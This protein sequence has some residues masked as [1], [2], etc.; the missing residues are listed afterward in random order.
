MK[1]SSTIN[2]KDLVNIA[3]YIDEAQDEMELIEDDTEAVE[4]MVR[5]LRDGEYMT[6]SE[7]QE[8]MDS[9]PILDVY[10]TISSQIFDY[11]LP[12]ELYKLVPRKVY[13]YAKKALKNKLDE[14]VKD[15]PKR[16]GF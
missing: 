7:Y 14:I 4:K 13:L 3:E 8:F 6:Q 15:P 9:D 5:I 16:I 10:A 1:I 2:L 11:G 12:E